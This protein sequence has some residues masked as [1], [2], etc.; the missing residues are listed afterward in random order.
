MTSDKIFHRNAKETN[1][2]VLPKRKS[3]GKSRVKL[4]G[5]I[6]KKSIALH[7]AFLNENIKEILSMFSRAF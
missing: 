1:R 5:K 4:N 3:E 6:Y 7:P 2:V